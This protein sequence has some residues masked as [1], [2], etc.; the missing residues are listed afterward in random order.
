MI[1]SDLILPD[2]PS[3]S[4]FKSVGRGKKLDILIDKGIGIKG[5]KTGGGGGGGGGMQR[6]RDR[7][8]WADG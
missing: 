6:E 3:L 1:R 2:S 4:L 5:K 7:K 8:N